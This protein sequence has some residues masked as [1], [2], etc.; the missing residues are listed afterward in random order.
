MNFE[1]QFNSMIKNLDNIDSNNHLFSV[2]EKNGFYIDR[3]YIGKNICRL[4][5]NF[6]GEEFK[7]R[8]KNIYFSDNGLKT[9]FSEFVKI[10][11]F[12][13]K[14]CHMSPLWYSQSGVNHDA[15][16]SD[17]IIDLKDKELCFPRKCFG[18]NVES[19]LSYKP[20]PADI[21]AIVKNKVDEVKEMMKD[22]Y[23]GFVE[24]LESTELVKVVKDR[25]DLL[26]MQ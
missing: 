18:H 6:Y 20:N 15:Y 25:F 12:E 16:V 17:L 23:K 9:L 10:Y 2:F 8:H 19:D 3:L 14:D 5:V 11:G 13:L 4:V 24:P 21:S 7:K 22:K 1:T 26:D